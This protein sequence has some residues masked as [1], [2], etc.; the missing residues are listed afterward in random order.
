MDEQRG[1][2]DV[3][4]MIEHEQTPVTIV[5]D[6]EDHYPELTPTFLPL[7]VAQHHGLTSREIAKALAA[8]VGFLCNLQAGF[9]RVSTL[10]ELKWLGANNSRK[11]EVRRQQQEQRGSN[12]INVDHD[13]LRSMAISSVGR[14]KKSATSAKMSVI[15]TRTPSTQLTSNPDAANTRNPPDRTTVVVHS[16]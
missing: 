5:G 3:A 13:F 2:L 1:A 10:C 14:R 15:A 16:A 7:F 4:R 9:L 8:C 6:F 11:G 12:E